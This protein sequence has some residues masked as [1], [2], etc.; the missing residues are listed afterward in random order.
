MDMLSLRRASVG[1]RLA[2]LSCALVAVIFAAFTWA[3]TRSAGAQVNEQ[4][5]T[6]I[7]EKNH[8][9]AGFKIAEE[10]ST[11]MQGIVERVSQVRAI[12]SEI[13]VA[14]REQSGGI[15]QVNLA[16]TQIGEATQQNATVVGEAERAAAELRAQAESLAQ[17]VSVFKLDASGRN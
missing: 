16:V 13:S 17:V 5:L 11:T 12:M 6:R 14:S 10:A 3:V 4:A 15:E 2:V 9:L 8:S 7:A 1:A